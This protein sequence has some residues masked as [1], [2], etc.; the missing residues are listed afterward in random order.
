MEG[1]KIF[2]LVII[3]FIYTLLMIYCCEDDI[4]VENM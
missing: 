3:K 1:L 2:V 4:M